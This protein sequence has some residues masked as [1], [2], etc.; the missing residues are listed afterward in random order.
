LA[1]HHGSQWEF[2]MAKEK[3]I[4]YV[5]NPGAPE[6][7]ASAATGFFV[8]NGNITITFESTRADH[9]E[10]P[11]PVYRAVVGRVVIP[12]QGAQA[13]AIG[14]FDFLEKQGFDFK[15]NQ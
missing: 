14:L 9:A 8:A 3:P 4:T 10:S 5:D 13:L 1:D 12:A 7:F 11:G 6:I 2:V 15:R